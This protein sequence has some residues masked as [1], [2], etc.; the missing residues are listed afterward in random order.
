MS[1]YA[2]T[3]DWQATSKLS[4]ISGKTSVVNSYGN[5][6]QASLSASSMKTSTHLSW[7]PRSKN[8]PR[9]P[10]LKAQRLDYVPSVVSQL[11][12]IASKTL[13]LGIPL[14]R[15]ALSDK[16][17]ELWNH[18]LPEHGEKILALRLEVFHRVNV[19][20]ASSELRI[21]RADMCISVAVH[22][23]SYLRGWRNKASAL[24]GL[25]MV[26]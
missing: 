10:E 23:R 1:S 4:E 16:M 5:S 24:I 22:D 21:A 3:V 19:F 11:G 20:L 26:L 15:V 8:E 17:L 18:I 7:L 13:T 6:K 2:T 25:M 9:K 14:P 12:R